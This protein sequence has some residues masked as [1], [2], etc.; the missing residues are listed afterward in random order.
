MR[1]Q[2]GM[3]GN[4][5]ADGMIEMD[6]DVGKLLKALDDLG[7]ADNTIVVFTHRQRPQPVLL[8]GRGDHAVPQRE[9]HELGRRL[10]RAGDGP[11]AGQDQAR[12]GLT[13]RCSPASTGSRRC[14]PPPAT[15]RQGTPAQRLAAQGSDIDL[16]GASR[17]LQPA[18]LPD[19]R[20][21]KSARNEFSYFNDDGELVAMRYGNWK[22]VFCEQRAAGRLRGLVRIRSPACVCRR[23]STCAWTRTSGPTSSPTSTTTGGSRTLYHDGLA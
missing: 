21:A 7:I 13:T 10:P 2:S 5:Y 16:Q 17:R 9:G 19:G 3:P 23:S 18:A 1:G 14:S 11:L 20:A 15:R 22:L 12:R 6:G 4:E 8:A